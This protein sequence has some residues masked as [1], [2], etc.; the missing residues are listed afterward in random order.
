MTD[1]LH[2]PLCASAGAALFHRDARREYWR[3]PVCALVYVP[4]A[5]HLA[6]EQGKAE[7]DLH[8]NGV[9]DPGYRRFP[10]RL[11]LCLLL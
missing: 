5:Y 10:A 6:A 9:T 8:Q 4:P 11:P 3:C 1:P 2:C 7:Y